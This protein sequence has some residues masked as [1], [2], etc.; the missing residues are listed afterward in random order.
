VADTTEAS[1]GG[2]PLPAAVAAGTE[3]EREAASVAQVEAPS[4]A[5][6]CIKVRRETEPVTTSLSTEEH[7]RASDNA[8]VISFSCQHITLCVLVLYLQQSALW[9]IVRLHHLNSVTSDSDLPEYLLHMLLLMP[10]TYS[11]FRLFS[12][13]QS[14]F[15]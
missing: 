12:V 4:A 13:V 9:K 6:P 10:R 3:S 7:S 8:Q 11:V 15:Y 14:G 2:A 5:E 1:N